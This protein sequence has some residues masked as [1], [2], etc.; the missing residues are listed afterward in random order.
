MNHFRKRLINSEKDLR[1]FKKNNKIKNDLISIKSGKSKSEE[2]E[3]EIVKLQ[4]DVEL[5]NQFSNMF[6]NNL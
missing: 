1:F 6:E 2:I 5:L 3:K 4:L